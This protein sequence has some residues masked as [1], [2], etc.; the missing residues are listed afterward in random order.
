MR[1]SELKEIA[2]VLAASRAYREAVAEV[3]RINAEL[4]EL[5]CQRGRGEV[6]DATSAT[7]GGK[8]LSTGDQQKPT[9]CR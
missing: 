4:F 2:A 6:A 1:R 8:K 3:M 9:A 7:G 5:W